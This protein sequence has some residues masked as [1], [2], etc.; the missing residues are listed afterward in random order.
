MG[1]KFL[2]LDS[3][4]MISDLTLFANYSKLHGVVGLLFLLLVVCSRVY[5][6]SVYGFLLV[7]LLY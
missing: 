2:K 5:A 7:G 4:T 6:G 1:Y 3:P